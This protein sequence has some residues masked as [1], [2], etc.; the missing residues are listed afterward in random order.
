MG[1]YCGVHLDCLR[2]GS[3]GPVV[4]I[5][6][7]VGVRSKIDLCMSFGHDRVQIAYVKKKHG[8]NATQTLIERRAR[9][10]ENFGV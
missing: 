7:G 1:E 9:E 2:R 4:C 10:F 6:C 8:L 3:R 5:L